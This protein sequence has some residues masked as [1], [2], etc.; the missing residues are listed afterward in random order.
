MAYGDQRVL[1]VVPARSGSK[2]LPN[3]NLAHVG[4][5]S[6]IAR[7]GRVLAAL[8]WIDARV[9]STDSP[10]YAEEGVRNGLEAPFLRPAELATDTAGAVETTQHAVSEMESRHGAPFDVI[11]IVEPTSPLRQ[12]S[13]IT[14]SV[15]LLLA[16][17]ACDAV[18]T[19]SAI[20][21]KCH[22]LKIFRVNDGRLEYFD[23][24][25]RAIVARQQ[26][27]PLYTRNGICYAL[28][29]ATLM[30]HGTILGRSTNAIVIDRPLVNI[31]S[32]VDLALAE[33][34]VGAGDARR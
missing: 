21:P 17:N 33:I 10:E 23:E 34:L 11:L 29:R 4:G 18:V 14:D 24:R 15:A 32:Y 13:D 28:R 8:P 12:P 30:D 3:K 19:V 27:E 22:P 20:D 31:D 9:I 5:L 6:L 16:D 2:G 7:A 1:A 25:G 26:L